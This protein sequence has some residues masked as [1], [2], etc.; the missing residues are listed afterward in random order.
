VDGELALSDQRT[1]LVVDTAADHQGLVRGE[2]P[3]RSWERQDRVL[4]SA[5]RRFEQLYRLLGGQQVLVVGHATASVCRGLLVREHGAF[6]SHLLATTR[7]DPRKR[8]ELLPIFGPFVQ[9]CDLAHPS[10]W[11]VVRSPRPPVRA[12]PLWETSGAGIRWAG[13]VYTPP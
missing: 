12:S 1:G 13:A 2:Q 5:T 11:T 3:V 6:S 8:R 10:H 9:M 7:A 4:H